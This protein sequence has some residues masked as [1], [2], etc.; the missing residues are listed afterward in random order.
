MDITRWMGYSSHLSPESTPSISQCVSL[1]AQKFHGLVLKSHSME[2]VLGLFL[3]KVQC[4]DLIITAA[5][6][7]LYQ[8]FTSETTSSSELT[9]LP[10]DIFIVAQ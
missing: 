2:T 1:T 4:Q 7:W 3:K 10:E 8:M 5:A 6:Q 9:Q